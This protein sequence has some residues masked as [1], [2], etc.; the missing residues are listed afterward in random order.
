MKPESSRRDFVAT[1]LA[2]SAVGMVPD[3]SPL[4]AKP[5]SIFPQVSAG[6]ARLRIKPRYHLWHVDPGIDWVETNTSHATLDWSIPVPRS[7][8]VLVDVWDHHYLKDTE[9][10]TEAVITEKLL[11]LLAACRSA[12]MPIIHAPSPTMAMQHPN[13]V[14]LVREEEMAASQADWPPPE[15]R[16]KT[17]AYQSYRRPDEPR[18]AELAKLRAGLTLHPK[19]QPLADEPVIATGEEL[20]RYCQRHKIL[21]LM[22]GNRW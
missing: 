21:W 20:H 8:I 4:F 19:V 22:G 3:V 16:D 9:A 5:S 18:E 7:A 11:P 14:R 17:G 10:R 12:A 6:N 13:W 1:S 2:A 15:F